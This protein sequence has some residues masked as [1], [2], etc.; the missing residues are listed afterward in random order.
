M[1][2]V[3]QAAVRGQLEEP[4][5]VGVKELHEASE[6]ALDLPVQLVRRDIDERTGQLRQ[7]RFELQLGS[8]SPRSRVHLGNRCSG[9]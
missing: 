1:R 6:P 7:E 3:E 4:A 2:R 5:P 9:R 8:L